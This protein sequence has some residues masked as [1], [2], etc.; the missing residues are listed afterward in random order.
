MQRVGLKDGTCGISWLNEWK[1]MDQG[2]AG[3]AMGA[4]LASKQLALRVRPVSAV[5]ELLVCTLLPVAA[6]V[7]V[8]VRPWVKLP[9]ALRV[10]APV[11][12]SVP[13]SPCAAK[14]LLWLAVPSAFLAL[15]PWRTA[16]APLGPTT[17]APLRTL[18]WPWPSV[19]TPVSYT[20]LT[21]PTI[22][23]V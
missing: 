22:C 19:V 7:A 5:Y 10:A 12:C 11:L 15:W 21:L 14:V 16:V 9:S 20:H 17:A 18:P 1:V 6:L 4:P 8:V 13:R 2:R 3:Q 23:S